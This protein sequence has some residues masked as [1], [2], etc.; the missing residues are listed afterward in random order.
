MSGLFVSPKKLLEKFNDRY[1]KKS[2][3]NG[4]KDTS[5]E[6]AATAVLTKMSHSNCSRR[7]PYRPPRPLRGHS[8]TL[9]ALL[10][11]ESSVR[12]AVVAKMSVD[13][14][15]WQLYVLFLCHLGPG[16]LGTKP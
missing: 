11:C 12:T 13:R 14:N 1:R 7:V 16:S 9:L 8:G 15:S 5:T 6:K 4:Q 10:Q 3:K 2:K